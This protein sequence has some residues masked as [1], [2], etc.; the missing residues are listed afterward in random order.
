MNRP[1]AA[2]D[3]RACADQAGSSVT[4]APD[5]YPSG[6]EQCSNHDAITTSPPGFRAR[7]VNESS[8]AIEARAR[9]QRCD[10]PLARRAN[11]P[12]TLRHP[13]SAARQ[14]G[15]LLA[16]SL[17]TQ[18]TAMAN[19][20]AVPGIPQVAPDSRY[21]DHG[22]GTVTDH[23]TGL[24]WAKCSR[25]DVVG[26]PV[27]PLNCTQT[28]EGE[29]DLAMV[30]ANFSTLAGYE[31]W[32][33]PNIKEL[34][35]LLET[36][37]LAD[38][39]VGV[40]GINPTVFP[41]TPSSATYWSSSTHVNSSRQAW[42]LDFERGTVQPIPKDAYTRYY[43]RFVRGGQWLEAFDSGE[44]GV[45]D[46]FAFTDQSGVAEGTQVTS[47]MI[48]LSGLTTVAGVLVSGGEYSLNG[49]PYT[50]ALARAFNGDTLRL[51]HVSG[52]GP[53]AVVGTTLVVGNVSDTFESTTALGADV[54]SDGFED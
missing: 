27:D 11:P 49:A 40:A 51:R 19:C 17:G 10:A 54:F 38:Y 41:A 46:A 6:A 1:L 30:Y 36:G 23:R 25:E 48:T 5:P 13:A 53:G 35:S 37:C 44:D 31:D 21:T 7:S 15:V 39:G 14:L 22:D 28:E 4:P 32:R 12:S 34:Y 42:T 50:S 3:F 2:P 33:L 26:T 20:P 47:D 29:W 9:W 52:T 8:I 24:M 18:A 16:L 45:P 43:A